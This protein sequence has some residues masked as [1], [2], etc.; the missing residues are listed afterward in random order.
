L[1]P[2]VYFVFDEVGTPYALCH[3]SE[4]NTYQEKIMTATLHTA[5]HHNTFGLPAVDFAHLEAAAVQAARTLRNVA[6]FAA[7]P[8]IGLVYAV[9]LP[10]VGLAM[11][12][13]MGGR[14]IAQAPATYTA[15]AAIR[16]VALFVTAPLIGLVYAVA[17]PL[18]GLVMI[19]RIAYQAYRTPA[20]VA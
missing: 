17:L 8:F 19:A 2:L 20:L 6:L 1:I 3:S 15:F 12:L 5:G 13:W 7:A 18:V 9:A 16:N 11:L 10:I 4:P 14:A